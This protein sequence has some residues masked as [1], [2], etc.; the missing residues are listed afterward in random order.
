MMSCSPPDTQSNSSS[1]KRYTRESLG[2]AKRRQGPGKGRRAEANLVAFAIT[3]V[4]RGRVGKG[5]SMRDEPEAFEGVLE[6][7]MRGVE[8]GGEVVVIELEV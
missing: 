6:V 4:E 5:E 7:L 8:E 3:D 1:E 2:S